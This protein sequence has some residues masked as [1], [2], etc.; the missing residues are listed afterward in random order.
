MRSRWL[1]IAAASL[2]VIASIALWP[3]LPPELVTHWNLRGDP[4]GSSSR[5]WAVVAGPAIILGLTLLLQVL[6]RIDP[7]RENYA[8]FADLYWLVVN[9]LLL[10]VLVLHVAVLAAG[11]GAGVSVQRVSA[12]GLAVL[13][14]VLGNSM[15]RLRPNWFMGIRT[16]WTLDSADVWRRTHRVAA[17]LFVGAGI[18]TGGAALIPRINPLAV[19]FV[20]VIVAALG[21]AAL[22]LVFW[23]QEGRS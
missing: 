4:D 14:L 21:S 2:A 11:A 22:S 18:M 3:K 9:G 17:W 6:P 10:C 19:G 20:V 16:P 12:G 1:G 13:M 8:R 23:L 15:G 7:W 5:V